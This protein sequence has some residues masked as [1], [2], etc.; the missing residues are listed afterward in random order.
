VLEQDPVERDLLFLGTEFGLW[1]SLDGGGRWLPFRHGFPT[2]SAMAMAVHPR[3][4]DLV[5]GTHGRSAYVVDD[6]SPLR[7]LTPETMAAPLHF[8]PVAPAIQHRIAQTGGERFPGDGE[9]RG[10]NRP[11]GALLAY[12]LDLPGLPHP[13]EEEERARKVAERAEAR[14]QKGA[15]AAP[16]VVSE[17]GKPAE[18]APAGAGREG[19]DVDKGPQVEIKVKDADGRLVRTFKAPA[20]LGLNR[21]AWDL[22]ADLFEEPKRDEPRFFE[23]SGPAVP[24]GDY[25]VTVKYK[26]HEATQ[27]VSVL[28]DPRHAVSAADR[29]AQWDA[30]QRA[31]ALQERASEVIERLRRTRADVE[32]LTKLARAAQEKAKAAAEEEGR[33]ADPPPHKELLESAKKLRQAIESAEKKLWVPPRTKGIVFDR[34][35]WSQIGYALRVLQSSFAAPSAGQLEHLAAAERALD[36]ALPEVERL[37]AEDVARFRQAVSASG[38]QPLAEE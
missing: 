19:E 2:V 31:G 11:Y 38:L 26:D 34:T 3:D 29:R 15:G 1:I 32:T 23:P 36:A 8:Y 18:T 9:F 33:E 20:K 22:R 12:S 14:R 6:I 24:P 16:D 4:H 27:T 37:Y 30:V 21:A 35:P 5:V 17:E 13:R 25:T 7:S 28:P 10:E